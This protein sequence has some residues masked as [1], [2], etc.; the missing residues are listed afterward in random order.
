VHYVGRVEKYGHLLDQVSE[1]PRI[2]WARL[3]SAEDGFCYDSIKIGV[4]PAHPLRSGQAAFLADL[5]AKFPQEEA[6]LHRYLQLVK[7]C[8]KKADIHFFG[9]LFP[10]WV[11]W[12]MERTVGRSFQALASRSVS[13]VL[14]ELFISS[15]LKALLLGQYGDYGMLPSEASFFIHAGIVAHYLEGA[16][17][18]V[19]GPQVISRALIPTITGAGG[20]V[21]VNAPVASFLIEGGVCCG[22]VLQ[23]GLSL[24]APVVVSGAG[25]YATQQILNTNIAAVPSLPSILTPKHSGLL[26]G[27]SHMYA[28]LGFEGDSADLQLPSYNLWVLPSEDIDADSAEYYADPFSSQQGEGEGDKEK[29]VLLFVGFPSAKDPSFREQHPGRSTCVVIT[30]A[31]TEWFQDFHGSETGKRPQGYAELK[32]RFSARLQRGLYAHFPQLRGRLQYCEVASPLTNSFY[33]GRAA[34]YGLT[35]QVLWP[36]SLNA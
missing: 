19:G 34:S 29:P 18:P 11:E 10:R 21:F 14:D 9:K 36:A 5:V 31:K 33:L 3:G 22:V 28:F 25:V 23:N 1:G 6:G 15:A 16:Y 20:K 32:D 27:V 26:G 4:N 35:H 24:S 12:I 2:R 13:N 7:E 30:E 17:Y 8:N